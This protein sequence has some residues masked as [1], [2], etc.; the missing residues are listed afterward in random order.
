MTCHVSVHPGNLRCN[1]PA[2]EHGLCERH[3]ADRERMLAAD[4]LRGV[5]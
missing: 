2:V 1:L 3:L 4:R 5:R